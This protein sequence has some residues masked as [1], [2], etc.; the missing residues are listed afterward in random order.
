MSV[1]DRSGSADNVL[2]VKNLRV[3]YRTP[4]GLIR[5]VNDVSFFLRRGER[6]GLV[7]ESGS[8]KT[9]TALSLMRLLQAPAEIEG[10]QVLL[11]GKDLLSLSQEEMRQARSA[12]ISLIPQ[13]AMNS[14]NPV[15]RIREQLLDYRWRRAVR[16]C[17]RV[18]KRG[19][20]QRRAHVTR[21]IV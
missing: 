15:T 17:V 2:E 6:L 10:G 16:W 21:V 1:T 13:G 18:G 12:E 8:G 19:I 4:R 3:G 5:A 11:D 20:A 9:T 7:G 14:L